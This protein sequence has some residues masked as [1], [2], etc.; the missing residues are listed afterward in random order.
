MT[1]CV[2]VASPV[3]Q[4]RVTVCYQIAANGEIEPV[5]VPVG[6]ISRPAAV[7]SWTGRTNETAAMVI[8]N[9][10]RYRDERRARDDLETLINTSPVGVVVFDAA[11]GSPRSFNREAHRIVDS[12][13]NPDQSPEDLL[14]LVT[15]RRSDDGRE[16]S[17]AEFPL[18]E[19]LGVAETVRAEDVV[20]SVP[21]GRSIT[22]LLNAT[23]IQSEGGA[24][25][26]VVVTMQDMADV[27]E[28]ERLRAEFLA[29]VSHELR[30][31]L[32][33]IKGS[34]S[35]V[36]DSPTDIDPAVVRQF[37]RI[38]G[39]QADHMHALVSDLLDV[40]HIETGTLPVSPEPAEVAVLVDRARSA[41]RN[42]GGRNNLDIDVDPELPLV[43]ADRR[44]IVQVLGNLL[45]NAARH[46]P[47]S[48]VPA[49]RCRLMDRDVLRKR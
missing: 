23:P 38:I 12:L 42:A 19:L 25:E 29:M 20:I 3:L 21:D 22:V 32:A 46:S 41:F 43:T 37:F 26:S 13:R 39:D 35:T 7:T 33:T 6:A 40:V 30:A 10:R 24:V 48:S 11:T 8:A 44:R 47:E 36:L 15:F 34:S 16:I 5:G 31:P 28:Q 17:L 49:T 2:T 1:L 18:S 14:A 9:A 45:T 27:E 4:N